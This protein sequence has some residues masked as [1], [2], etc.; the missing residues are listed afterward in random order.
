MVMN[1]DGFVV[2]G[3]P[4]NEKKEPVMTYKGGIPV[5]SHIDNFL[6]CLKTRKQPNC[7]VEIAQ[8]SGSA[9]QKLAVTAGEPVT[10]RLAG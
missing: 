6:D 3:D 8:R 1:D 10:L 5:E 2:F 9:A 4:A 7:T